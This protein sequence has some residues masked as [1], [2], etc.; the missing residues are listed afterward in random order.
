[1]GKLSFFNNQFCQRFFKNHNLTDED[2]FK[3]NGGYFISN[4]SNSIFNW[5]GLGFF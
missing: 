4:L 5:W 1:M 3:K 2:S